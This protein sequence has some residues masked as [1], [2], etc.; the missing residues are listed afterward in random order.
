MRLQRNSCIAALIIATWATAVATKEVARPED[1]FLKSIELCLAGVRS[2]Q[3]PRDAGTVEKVL[4]QGSFVVATL[5]S[6]T[7]GDV[8]VTTCR[9]ATNAQLSSGLWTQDMEFQIQEIADSA[10]LLRINRVTPGMYFADCQNVPYARYALAVTPTDDAWTFLAVD[11]PAVG[12][13]CAHS[14]GKH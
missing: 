8:T 10:D 5:S 2:F 13:P 7:R 4:T 9:P 12:A 3:A 1:N 14:Y 6:E 11:S